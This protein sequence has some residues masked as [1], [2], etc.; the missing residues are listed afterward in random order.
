MLNEQL[1]GH[2]NTKQHVTN[3]T[4]SKKVFKKNNFHRE[5]A[6]GSLK[7]KVVLSIINFQSKLR[8]TFYT[9]TQIRNNTNFYKSTAIKCMYFV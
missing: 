6:H 5:Y 8:I 1:L 3:G 2:K 7:K 4:Q 9:H